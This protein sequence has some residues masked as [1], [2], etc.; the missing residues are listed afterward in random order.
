MGD[1]TPQPMR[2]GEH[3][4]QGQQ[5]PEGELLEH[6]IW[7]GAGNE[8]KVVTTVDDEGRPSEGTGITSEDALADA[9]KPGQLLGHGFDTDPETSPH[10]H[11][12]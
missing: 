1:E 10:K 8:I 7:D 6:S 2:E 11:G 4:L 3:E 5:T 12:D 9:K